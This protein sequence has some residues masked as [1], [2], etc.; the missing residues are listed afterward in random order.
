MN[1]VLAT[2][3][4]LSVCTYIEMKLCIVYGT[5]VSKSRRANIAATAHPMDYAAVGKAVLD[6]GLGVLIWVLP[7]DNPLQ[8]AARN[9][10]SNVASDVAGIGI[11]F[12]IG[13][14]TIWLIN[15]IFVSGGNGPL[16]TAGHQCYVTQ[17]PDGSVL[18][19]EIAHQQS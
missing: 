13:E 1:Y 7:A 6:F 3:K 11:C 2:T 17:L 18:A 16:S 19:R 12:L 9:T 5:M 4:H 10:L 14:I 15:E 8:T